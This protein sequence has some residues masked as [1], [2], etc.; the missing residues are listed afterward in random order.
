MKTI[1]LLGGITC[2][3]SL[4]YY[5]LINQMTRERLG[6]HHSA[7][8]VMISVDFA[9]IQPLTES[10][11]WDKVLA[12]L[13]KA[14]RGIERG[15]ADL[16]LL[17]A[18]TAHKLFEA[19]GREIAIP[20]VHIVDATA[21]EIE[22]AGFKKVGLLGTRFTM[23]EDFFK[24]RLQEKYGIEA[25]VPG[26]E[27]RE[28]VHRIIIDELALGN[29]KSESRDEVSKAMDGLG[30]KGVQAIILGC[31]E[32]PLLITQDQCRIPLFDTTTIHARAAVD[33]ALA[34]QD[35]R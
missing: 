26:K 15:G 4:V 3:S 9:E 14:A 11:E 30:A 25:V 6:G 22:K 31:T 1:G 10:G 18:N 32:L 5:Q 29:I 27:E 33:L 13:L 23:E 35:P 28:R 19:I 17:C 24:G 20:I 12:I 16:L 8:S 34:A 7:K 2:E 21:R